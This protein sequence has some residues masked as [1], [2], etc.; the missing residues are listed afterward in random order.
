MT[1]EKILELISQGE[2]VTI[3]FKECK[4]EITAEVYPTVVSAGISLWVLL[5]TARF[6]A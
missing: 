2:G 6:W 3:E 5:M 1:K 4:N